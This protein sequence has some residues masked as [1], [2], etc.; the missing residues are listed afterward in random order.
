MALEPIS[1]VIIGELNAENDEIHDSIST[2]SLSL[3][4]DGSS[5]LQFS[6]ADPSLRMHDAGYFVLRRPVY[7]DGLQYEIAAIEVNHVATDTDAV[8]VTCRSTAVQK[9]KRDKGA[10]NFGTI[11]PTAFA[12]QMA[13][14]FGLKFFGQTSAAKSAIIRAQNERTDESTWDVLRRLARDL[15]YVVFEDGDMLYFTSEEFLLQHQPIIG[16]NYPSASTDHFYAH[17]FSLRRSDDD[18]LGFDAEYVLDRTNATQLRP[19]MGI[20]LSGVDYFTAKH[21]IDSVEWEPHAPNPVSVSARSLEETPDTGCESQTFQRGSRGD[22]VK[23]IQQ[24][25]GVTADGIFGPITEAAVKKFQSANGLSPTGIVGPETWAFIVK[26]KRSGSSTTT[27]T[28]PPS[29][30]N[31]LASCKLRTFRQGSEGFC[32]ALIQNALDQPDR[33]DGIFD[34]EVAAH[35]RGFQI[36]NGLTVDGIVGLQTWNALYPPAGSEV[37]K[38]QETTSPFI[39]E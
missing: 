28:S 3:S 25:V 35:V 9:M 24:A 36:E 1:D 31:N 6:V 30:A 8:N 29:A 16:I 21:M 11:S 20:K 7:F 27:T 18:V 37:P 13:N 2:I 15:E 38:E 12:Y 26:V 22:C 17:E 39:I 4:A 10:M 5:Q 19:G 14:K 23:R 32:V 34:S 33:N